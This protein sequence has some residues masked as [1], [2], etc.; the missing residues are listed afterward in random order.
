MHLA[1]L[2]KD[3]AIILGV[4]GIMSFFCRK[5]HLPVVLGYLIAG[6][7]VGPH[8]PPFI[9]VSDVP[10]INTWAELG[11]IFLMFTLG[12]EFS[13]RKLAHVGLS[14]VITATTEIFFLLAAG[15]G[16]G[17]LM[18]WNHMQSLILG[19]MLSISST[20]I[21][22]KALDELNL[23]KHLFAQLIFGVLIVEDLYAIL[24]LVAL[25][26]ISQQS[27]FSIATFSFAS[28]KLLFL[29]GSWFITG[30]FIIPKVIKQA[31]RV[32]NPEMVT[33]ISLAFCLLL[34]VLA[35]HFGYSP[36]LGAFIMGSI[37][38]ETSLITEIEQRMA[39]LKD[40]FGAIFFVSI[41]MLI[42]P[43]IM[44]DNIGLIAGLSL[45]ILVGKI[46]FSTIGAIASGQSVRNSVQVGMGLAQIGEFSFII[47]G[48]GVA[49]GMVGKELYPIA[50]GV[51]IITTFATPFLIKFS[52]TTGQKFEQAAP[53]K[54]KDIISKYGFWL[55]HNKTQLR[56]HEDRAK[57][58]LIWV[59]NGTI[60]T[61]IFLLGR[62]LSEELIKNYGII[63]FAIPLTLS[64]PFI[65]AML[66]GYRKYALKKS[67]KGAYSIPVILTPLLS[68][69][70]IASLSALYFPLK[71]MIPLTAIC[72][73]LFIGLTYKKLELSY[74]WFE[75][76]FLSSFSSQKDELHHLAPWDIH[77]VN[78]KAHPNSSHI[79]K[80]LLKTNFRSR[81]GINVVAI[82]R[83]L[84]NIIAPGPHEVILPFDEL[85]V[86]G[87]DEQ[88]EK[89]RM[90]LDPPLQH[91]HSKE[92]GNDEYELRYVIVQEIPTLAGKS[93]LESGI[94]ENFHSLIVGLERDGKRIVNP[95]VNTELS[96]N[97]KIW[98]VGHRDEIERLLKDWA[99]ANS[100]SGQLN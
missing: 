67:K 7:I 100:S 96:L 71:Y 65:W 34:V 90:E 53:H 76:N 87:S 10:S 77:L 86:L 2:I 83:G 62:Q 48:T 55:E 89:L 51:S 73:T 60:V 50:V 49:L 36:A 39:P 43:L 37:L 44:R 22:I 25:T 98:I 63:V 3:L 47:V 70:W 27:T 28:I 94:R 31:G 30:Y 9:L 93:I 21:I 40:L 35:N 14:A 45:F 17:I 54:M 46:L 99:G 4:A 79:Q 32:S 78:L 74:N 75:K 81:F 15:Y 42:D 59:M 85:V 16:L 26:T 80:S 91:L 38:A 1:P 23:K 18:G 20:T 95:H 41:G 52:A 68:F 57:L 72:L 13:F 88:V 58:A 61:L 66:F 33:I 64:S 12:L 97:D 29:I 19:C 84:I 5:V 82:K 8:T 11:V 92:I 56:A 24:I 69:V 6:L